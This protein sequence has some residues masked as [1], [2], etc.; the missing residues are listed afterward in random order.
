MSAEPLIQGD[1]SDE[2][3]REVADVGEPVPRVDC[4]GVRAASGRH[5]RLHRS[6]D[7]VIHEDA[8]R[9]EADHEHSALELA[10][11]V[12]DRPEHDSGRSG[13]Q[14]DRLVERGEVVR[15][16]VVRHRMRLTDEKARRRSI[17]DVDVERDVGDLLQTI[18]EAGSTAARQ[19]SSVRHAASTPNCVPQASSACVRALESTT[20]PRESVPTELIEIE[21]EPTARA[22][23]RAGSERASS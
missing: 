6:P 1:D 3:I 19:A 9:I 15:T 4:Q 22:K 11:G 21:L 10:L 14:R 17:G 16:V 5:L 13:R 18:E 2:R 12:D 20:I 23:G 8:A 7:G